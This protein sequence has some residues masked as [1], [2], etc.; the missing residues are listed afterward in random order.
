[1]RII[2]VNRRRVPAPARS[3]RNFVALNNKIFSPPHQQHMT[4]FQIGGVIARLTAGSNLAHC[5][6]CRR[7]L[8]NCVR[9]FHTIKHNSIP[10]PRRRS[11]RHASRVM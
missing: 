10:R 5:L 11:P 3:Q 7:A 8:Q 6:A 1:L 2:G 9:R 4:S